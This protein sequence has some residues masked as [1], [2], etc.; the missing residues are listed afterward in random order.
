MSCFKVEVD[1]NILRK[2]D[3][4]IFH[5]LDSEAMKRGRPR[6]CALM[7]CYA[8]GFVSI[9]HKPPGPIQKGSKMRL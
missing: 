4:N 3:Q 7:L 8:Y 5:Q 1:Q 9:K 6:R 2:R